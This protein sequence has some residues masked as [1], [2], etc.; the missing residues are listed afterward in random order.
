MVPTGKD[1]V[2]PMLKMMA[3]AKG[4]T[5]RRGSSHLT[6]MLESLVRDFPCSEDSVL[7]F[8]IK[9]VVDFKV[10]IVNVFTIKNFNERIM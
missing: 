5:G 9:N 10:L 2:N 4:G 1:S 7:Y 8:T 3:T 6:G